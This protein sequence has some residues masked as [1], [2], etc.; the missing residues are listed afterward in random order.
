MG[1]KV[2]VITQTP[3]NVV[4]EN[5]PYIDKISVYEAK[6]W[7]QDFSKWQDWF[8]MRAREYDKFA[9]LVALDRM[10]ARAVADPDMVLVAAG[11]SAQAVRRQ[12]SRNR[13]RRAG[14]A[15]YIRPA[16]LPDRRG[17]ASKPA[18]PSASSATGR[19]SAGAIRHAHRQ[20]SIPMH[21]W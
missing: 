12:L 20:E 2:E 19:S 18:S 8:R 9:N 6:D 10:P 4:F 7:P 14:R 11:I 1:Y 5:N 16:V 17:E 13:A 3:H 21:R 15:A